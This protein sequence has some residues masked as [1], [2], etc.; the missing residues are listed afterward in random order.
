[1]RVLNNKRSVSFAL[2]CY[3]SLGRVWSVCILHVLEQPHNT[4]ITQF[5]YINHIIMVNIWLIFF[6]FFQVSFDRCTDVF[7]KVWKIQLAS[8]PISV[9]NIII[10]AWCR[11]WKVSVV[12]FYDSGG[13]GSVTLCSM[14]GTNFDIVWML[15]N[16]VVPRLNAWV[17][18]EFLSCK[19]GGGIFEVNTYTTGRYCF[20]MDLSAI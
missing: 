19:V 11:Q 18:I 16:T 4:V 20:Q 12:L 3:M 10:A 15:T 7:V 6:I 17:L 2:A 14:C 1:M 9:C 5:T 13:I 8:L